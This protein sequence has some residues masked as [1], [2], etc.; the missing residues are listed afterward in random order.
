MAKNRGGEAPLHAAARYGHVEVAELRISNDSDI[1]AKDY[2]GRTALLI[3]TELFRNRRPP[4]PARGEGSKGP[5]L[6][7]LAGSCSLGLG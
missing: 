3:A 6:R 2:K 7:G 1:N 5:L 4:P